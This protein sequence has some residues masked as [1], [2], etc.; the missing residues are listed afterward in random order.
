MRKQI[1]QENTQTPSEDGG[2][3]RIGYRQIIKQKEFCKLILAGLINRFGD[4]VD[5][6]AFTW[7][8]YEVTGS[9]SWSAIIFALNKVPTILLQPFAGAA[10]ERRSKKKLVILSDLARG[11]AVLALALSYVAGAVNPW[12]LA[13][14]TLFISSVEAFGQ[15]AATALIPQILE[16]KYF[17]F[18]MSLNS[19]VSTV[20]E[21][22]GTAS[23]GVIIGVFGIQ[24]AIIIDAVT[25]FVS[26]LLK[27]TLRVKEKLQMNKTENGAMQ[28]FKDLKEGILYLGKKPVIR[29]LCLMA[30]FVNAMLVPIN[31]FQAP[32]V[33]EVLGQGSELLSVMGVVEALAMGLGAVIYPYIAAKWR[34]RGFLCTSGIL[35]A[36]SCAVL[37]AGNLFQEHTAAVYVVTSIACFGM[38]LGACM[39]SSITAVE[40]MKAVE[41][42]YLAR[43]SALLNAGAVAAMP[44]TSF[45][46]SFLVKY[47]S[48]KEIILACSVVCGMIFLGIW[49]FK[50]PVEEEKEYAQENCAD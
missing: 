45:F 4:S 12:L 8:V 9:A 3:E 32:I 11:A 31:S 10:V 13:V 27:C 15:P 21:L 33:S 40:F 29:N 36:V 26:A 35:L 44:V 23:A 47:I 34:A 14:F 37:V 22:L 24:A 5:A 16:K 19:I 46:M 49:L 50:V 6:I 1:S 43:E 38:A 42:N 25:F 39:A 20:F 48:V 30:L 28:Y 18:G 41:E 17:S 7:L 2:K